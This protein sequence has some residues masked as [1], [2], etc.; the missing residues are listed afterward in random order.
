MTREYALM[1]IDV[2]HRVVDCQASFTEANRD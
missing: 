1:L 2:G